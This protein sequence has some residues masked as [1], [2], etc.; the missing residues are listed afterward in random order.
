[1]EVTVAEPGEILPERIVD[2]SALVETL[3]ETKDSTEDIIAKML[4]GKR[5]AKPKS[6]LRELATLILLNFVK[7]RQT[8]RSILLEEDRVKAETERAKA[9]VDLTTLQL[10]NLMYEKNHYVKAIKACKDFKSKYPD[11][12]LVPV[13]EFLRDCPEDIKSPML[14]TD[15]SHDLMLKRLNYE[16]FQRKELCKLREELEHQKK[17]LQDTIANRKKF[18]SSLPSHLKTLKKASLPVQQQLGFVHT[19]KLKQHQMAELLP[20]SL[21]VIYSQLVAQK[22]A[23]GENIE[24]EVVGSIKDAQTFARQL[25]NKDSVSTNLD[26]SKLEDDAPDEDDDGQRRRKRPKKIPSRENID[27]SGVYQSH[28]L[29]IILDIND[30]GSNSQKLITLKFEF[31]MKL[32]VVCVEVDASEGPSRNDILGNLFPD[33][34]GLDVPHQSAKLSI[35]N[36]VLFDETRTSRPYKWAQHLA[37]IDF[38]PEVSP[39]LLESNGE[40][41]EKSCILSGLSLY[42]QQNRVQ[43]VVQRIRARKKA[44]IALEQILGSLKKLSWPALMSQHVPWASYKPTC[45]FNGWYAPASSGNRGK[46]SPSLEKPNRSRD[47]PRMSA[48]AKKIAESADE[49]EGVKEDGELPS[50][51]VVP[52]AAGES[53]ESE[54]S[55]REA[56]FVSKSIVSIRK[57]PSIMRKIEEDVELVQLSDSETEE[58]AIHQTEESCDFGS[59]NSW[60]DFGMEVFTLVLTK[61]FGGSNERTMKLEAKIQLTPEYP[62]RPPRF[63]LKLVQ[64]REDR[65]EEIDSYFFNELCAIEAEVNWQVMRMIPWDEE[66]SVLAHQVIRVAMLFDRLDADD[67]DTTTATGVIVGR[68]NRSFRGRDHRKMIS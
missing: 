60:A 62:L 9:P 21:Y 30:D 61:K 5:E 25:A 54:H 36:S 64:Q 8:N 20:P 47:A 19:K 65:S 12:E 2:P 37:G 49:M 52:S 63:D 35:G 57:K 11:I 51:L 15:S 23:F 29:K 13:E 53:E 55:T 33:D 24:L 4:A 32:N 66:D 16:L 31:L 56:N 40:N 14:S 43:T 38:L 26:D 59:R 41:S 67:G 42:R 39:L 28:P 46:S 7:L 1:M 3:R 17:A 50:S 18:L 34:T 6:Q 68:R 48:D 44:Q 58:E 22:E 27:Q 45:S 10:H